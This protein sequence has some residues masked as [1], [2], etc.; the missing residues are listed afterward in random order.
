MRKVLYYLCVA[1]VLGIFVCI[2]NG[3]NYLKS[4]RSDTDD[5]NLYLDRLDHDVVNENWDSAAINSEKLRRAWKII[6]PRI[7]FSVEKSEIDAI[8][9]NL[10]RIQA[11]VK[12]KDQ[13]GSYAELKEA[14]EHWNDL[15][16]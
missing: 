9:V 12:L 11:Y 4:P 1:A 3:G 7:Q 6:S 13:V 2:M 5:V 14:N 16:Q 8:N 10:A 15:N